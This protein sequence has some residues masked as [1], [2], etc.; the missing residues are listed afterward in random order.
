MIVQNSLFGIMLPE[1]ENLTFEPVFY[2]N[3]KH[4]RYIN[5]TSKKVIKLEPP[6]DMAEITINIDTKGV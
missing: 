3:S 1:N 6:L 4:F 2:P 5:V